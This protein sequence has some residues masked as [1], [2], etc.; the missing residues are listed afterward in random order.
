MAAPMPLAGP[1]MRATRPSRFRSIA[2]VP[3]VEKV[4]QRLPLSATEQPRQIASEQL[5]RQLVGRRQ[6]L[7]V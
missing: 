6:E 4:V 1:V 2:V 5:F 3:F 7:P